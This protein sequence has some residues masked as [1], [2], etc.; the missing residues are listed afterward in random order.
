MEKV[1]Q[2]AKKIWELAK[3]NKKVTIGII[4]V[5]IILYELIIK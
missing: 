1:K 3:A 4:I 5:V 2:Y